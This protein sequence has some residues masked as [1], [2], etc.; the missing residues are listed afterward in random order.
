MSKLKSLSKYSAAITFLALE[1]FAL[2]AFN[3]SG[4][5]VLFGS[6]SLALMV[7][8]ILF[9]IGE[10][11]LKGFSNVALFYIPL[12]LFTL[13]T[14]VGIYSLG[15]ASIGDY[16]YAELVFIPLGILPIAFCGYLLSFDK[17]FKIKTFLL[18][19][20]SALAVYCLINLFFNVINFGAFYTLIYKDYYL[21][22][23]GLKSLVPA[24][25]FAYTLEGFKFI[26]V[27]MNHYVL[28]PILLL[29]S[30]VMLLYLSPKKE[31]VLFI[32]YAVFTLVAI[33]C[34]VLVPSIIS[35]ASIAVIALL[36]L[37]I[38]LAKRFKLARKIS[39]IALFVVI[40]IFVLGY[41]LFVLNGQSFASGISNLIA[42]NELLDRLFNT[43]RVTSKYHVLIT[44]LFTGDK[45]LGFAGY[46]EI[47]S[48]LSTFRLYEL[49][50]GFIF[51]S[52]MTS[53]VLG[54][55]GLFGFIT[56]GFIS[57]KKYFKLHKDEFHLQATLLLFVTV[58]V[59]FSMFFN[60]GEY[61]LYYDIYRPIYLTAPFMIMIFIF[62]YVITKAH[63][64]E[65]KIEKTVAQETK[66][67]ES[68][69]EQ[70]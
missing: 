62:S 19:V 51:D 60:S 26:E 8:L 52:Y 32:V 2:M 29:T 25:D 10:I 70:I 34:L 21:Y 67:G 69:N 14:T 66:E 33:L 20:F 61:A 13:L 3:F 16:S 1:F 38:F 54:A 6:L 65:K 48:D 40:G 15:H 58:F 39:K 11:K 55:F 64:E 4:S 63:P 46:Y 36:V 12:F 27:E 37:L 18:V 41:L 50:G 31:K 44:D 43:S 5:Y 59:G 7:L 23:K 57:F 56:C 68:L 47:P 42:S 53:G 49:S 9:N 17:H 22:Y 35:L 45:F 24:Q 30:S 28:Y